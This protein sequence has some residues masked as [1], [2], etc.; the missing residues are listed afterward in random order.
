MKSK[1]SKIIGGLVVLIITAFV[2]L[3]L[4]ID[5]I[6][7]SGLEENGSELLQTVVT[8]DAVSISLFSGNGSIS[9]FTVHN[10]ENYSDEPALYIQDASMKIDLLSLFSDQ[11]VINEII[12][13]SPNLFFEQKGIGANLKTLNDNMNLAFD[14]PSETTLIIDYLMIEDG[15]VKVSTS[16]ERERTTEVSFAQFTLNDIGRDGNNTIKQSVRQVLEPLMQK[17]ITEALKSGV[18]DQIENKVRDL[19]NN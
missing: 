3:T 6:I 16:I 10:P 4:S 13:K 11:I 8:V 2:V 12:V 1:T 5:G 7:K 19:L 14:E 15:Q 18:T 9:G 17:A